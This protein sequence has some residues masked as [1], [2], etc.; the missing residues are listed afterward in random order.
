VQLYPSKSN[1]EI[2]EISQITGKEESLST[3]N[4]EHFVL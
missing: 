2:G 4:Q 1:G 3:I